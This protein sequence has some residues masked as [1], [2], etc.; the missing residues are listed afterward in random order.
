MDLA[1]FIK[2]SLVQLARGIEDANTALAGTSAKVNPRGIVP[3][4]SGATKFY[5]YLNET[6]AEQYLR[7]V[8]EIE[9]DVAVHAS[10]G[11]ETKGG[12]GILVGAIGLGSQGRSQAESIS[13]SRLKFTVPMVLPVAR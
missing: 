3:S 7:V 12:I 4:P 10:E 9:F 6:Q 8:Q 13:Q 2:E 1:T 5:G 11:T